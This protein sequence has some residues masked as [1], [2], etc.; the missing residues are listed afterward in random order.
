M[1][2]PVEF[3]KRRVFVVRQAVGADGA[4]LRARVPGVR[5]SSSLVARWGYLQRRGRGSQR[6][7]GR[8]RCDSYWNWYCY[9]WF[10]LGTRLWKSS[11]FSLGYFGR[12]KKSALKK[13]PKVLSA[14]VWP[15]L[16][17]WWLDSEKNCWTSLK[18]RIPCRSFRAAS[19]EKGSKDPNDSPAEAREVFNNEEERE[20]AILGVGSTFCS[21]E[22]ESRLGKMLWIPG[23]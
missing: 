11:S 12:S 20:W 1:I 16:S 17:S 22:L 19:C 23:G 21:A 9:T 13:G 10:Q 6:S 5:G 2:S 18:T 4:L 3:P 14:S 15:F 7:G 8:V